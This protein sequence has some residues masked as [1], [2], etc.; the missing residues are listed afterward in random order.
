MASSERDDEC[1]RS[2]EAGDPVGD[3]LAEGHVFLDDLVGI[4][5]GADPHQL[6]RGVKLAAQHGQHV[7]PGV[8]LALQQ[9]GD[10]VAVHF[11]AHSLFQRDG[12]GLMRRLVEHGGEAEKLAL[13]RLVDDDFLVVLV[14]GGDPHRAGDHDVSLSARIADL[15]D[16]LA[17]S[18][19]S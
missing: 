2:A 4:A 3:A 17:R 9:N 6:L 15:P 11:Q 10:I 8:R 12:L 16:A 19:R 1:P 13:R 18:E 14:H 5:A 7:H